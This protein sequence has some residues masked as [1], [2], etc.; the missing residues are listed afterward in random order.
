MQPHHTQLQMWIEE[1]KAVWAQRVFREGSW[2]LAR[3]HANMLEMLPQE[4]LRIWCDSRACHVPVLC[5][6]F[7]LLNRS[8]LSGSASMESIQSAAS[9]ADCHRSVESGSGMKP[10][11]QFRQQGRPFRQ[12]SSARALLC[13]LYSAPLSSTQ[14]YLL[15]S[16]VV[17]CRHTHHEVC[18][19]GRQSANCMALKGKELSS[20]KDP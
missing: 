18:M 19:Q 3:S 15:I 14:P 7:A 6:S 8:S 4:F 13:C 2:D 17:D 1:N 11:K 16:P 9:A 10:Q 20:P 12:T 5:H